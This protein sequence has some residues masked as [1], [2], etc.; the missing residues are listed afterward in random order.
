MFGTHD[1]SPQP[2]LVKATARSTAF[3]H[4]VPEK[5]PVVL[6][7]DDDKDSLFLLTHILSQYV[8]NTVI[9]SEGMKALE[10]IRTIQPDL[11][12]LDIWMPGMSGL[13]IIQEVR[14]DNAINSIPV[15]AVTALAREQD[16][17]NI[18]KAGCDQYISKPYQLEEMETLLSLYLT[19][20]DRAL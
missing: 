9:E 7:V 11:I 19:Y 16:R 10:R 17:S 20:R 8:C 14:R 18:M 4:T 5:L 13:E 1:S 12:L 15:V 3:I 6:V 2:N